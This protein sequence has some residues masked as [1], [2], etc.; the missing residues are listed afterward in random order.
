MAKDEK[1]PRPEETSIAPTAPQAPPQIAVD[2]TG[3]HSTYVNWYRVTGTP[4]ELILD[5]GL[6]PEHGQIP[7]Q[8]IKLTERLVLSFYTAKRLLAHLQF[9]VARHEGLFGVIELD[10]QRRMRAM[11]GGTA[12]PPTGR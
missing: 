3:M 11:P 2:T 8:P 9:A 12:P 6:N 10:F 4:E 5:F 7:T 1:N